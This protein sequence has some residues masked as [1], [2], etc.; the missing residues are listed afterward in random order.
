ME[1]MK[2]CLI[3]REFQIKKVSLYDILLQFFK[4]IHSKDLLFKYIQNTEFFMT[5]KIPDIKYGCVGCAL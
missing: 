4:T 5:H 3:K 2:F 1:L